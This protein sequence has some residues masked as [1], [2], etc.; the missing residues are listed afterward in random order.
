MSVVKS[1]IQEILWKYVNICKDA[2]KLGK[3][4]K[5]KLDLN[6]QEVAWLNKFWNP[7]NV[8]ISIEGCCIATIKQYLLILSNLNKK[9]KPEKTSISKEVDYFKEK[10]F[11]IKE[12]ADSYW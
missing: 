11:E 10:I 6:K 2:Y 4:Y 1:I 3:Q 8:F 12:I 9:L 7:S 5:D